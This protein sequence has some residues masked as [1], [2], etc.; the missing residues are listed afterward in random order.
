MKEREMQLRSIR[1]KIR[2]KHQK[3][4]HIIYYYYNY[5]YD[6]YYYYYHII[7]ITAEFLI[8]IHFVF[9]NDTVSSRIRLIFISLLR[10]EKHILSKPKKKILTTTQGRPYC[11][12]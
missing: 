11:I 4:D 5:N 3:Y 2:K 7:M 1:K 12:L 8:F 10:I 9:F 6:Y